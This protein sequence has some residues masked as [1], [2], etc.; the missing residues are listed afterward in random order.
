MERLTDESELTGEETVISQ[1][2]AT[3]QALRLIS[4]STGTVMYVSNVDDMLDALANAESGD[5]VVVQNDI[6]SDSVIDVPAGVSLVGYGYQLGSPHQIEMK[7]KNTSE[8]VNIKLR[9]GSTLAGFSFVPLEPLSCVV[10]TF[11]AFADAEVHYCTFNGTFYDYTT[12]LGSITVGI[13]NNVSN[14]LVCENCTFVD[15]YTPIQHNGVAF[16]GNNLTWN[17]GAVFSAP[18]LPTLEF[19]HGIAGAKPASNCDF[20][21][22]ETV[23][24]EAIEAFCD[25]LS[26][27]ATDMGFRING[28]PYTPGEA[29]PVSVPM[30]LPDGSVLFYDRGTSYGEYK[31]NDSGYPERIDGAVDDGSAES[32]NWRY[33]I[34][35]QHD[36][37]DGTPRWGAYG[38]DTGLTDTAIGVGLSN[39]DAMIAEYGDND[40]YWWKLIKEKRDS[41]GL[42]WFMPSKDELNMMYDNRT[43]ITSQGGDAFQTDHPYWSSSEVSSYF[44]WYQNFSNGSQY[45]NSKNGACHC[46]LLRRV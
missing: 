31:I 46:R 35:D 6:E 3:A 27:T 45:E 24:V 8:G 18:S 7:L 43:V 29:P 14:H 25:T 13:S 36:P 40:N 15:C 9:E 2:T 12:Y 19:I 16:T 26:K 10:G 22:N 30:A 28:T 38:I 42:K 5:I 21:S 1:N 33:L 37:N 11:D 34:C 23:T 44:V 32:Q 41:T 17:S 39:T 4:P 20:I